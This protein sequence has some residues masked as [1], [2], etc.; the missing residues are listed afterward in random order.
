MNIDF[1]NQIY[2]FRPWQPELGRVYQSG[3]AFDTETT[4]IDDARPYLTPAYVIGAAFDGQ[5]GFFVQR[6]DVAS[7]F[8]AHAGL[9]IAFHNA[10]FDLSVI[11]TVAPKIDI[12]QAVEERRIW[13]TQLLHRLHILGAEG[14]SASR[15]GQS[16]LEHCA[17]LYL[18]IELPKDVTDSAGKPVRLSYGQWLNRAP[19]DIEAVY[20]EYLAKDVVATYFVMVKLWDAIH[21]LAASSREV[22]GFVSDE[23]LNFCMNA[24]GPQTHHIQ[25]RAAIVLKQITANGL[26]LD[27]EHKAELSR[28]LEAR[29]AELR[30]EL[31]K[32]GY[33]PG[34][35]SEKALQAI[36]LRIERDQ[37][38]LHLPRTE[39]GKIQTSQEALQE[40]AGTSEF[41]GL[42]LEYRLTQKLRS[43]FVDK[44]T[45]RRIHPSFDVLATT[46]RTTSFGEINAQN[47]PKDD[48][49]RSC[50][51]P[52][53]GHV[54]FD[55]DY[56]TVEMATLAE[57]CIRQFG[58]E[59][60]MAAAIN[61][62]K[63][64]HTMVAARVL[65][66]DEAA[67]T[68]PDRS[69]AKP[70]NFGKPG[71]MGDATLQRYAKASYE[72]EL[73]AEEVLAFSA[74]WHDTF[75]EMARFLVDTHN[76]PLELAK[77]LDL[78]EMSRREHA[79]ENGAV[80]SYWCPDRHLQPNPILGAMCIKVLGSPKPVTRKGE[81]YSDSDVDYF[82]AKL[83]AKQSCLTAALQ[84]DICLRQ[85][86]PQL[87][88]AVMS[89]VGRAGVFTLTGRLRGA[90]TY[91]ARHNTI[92]QG[93]AADG[94]KLGLWL[95]WRAG[96]RIVNFIHDQVLIEVP[97]NSDLDHHA[98]EIRRLMI[99]GMQAV[100][101]DVR[102][103]VSLA[104]SERWHKDA[105]AVYDNS[106]R[107]RLWQPAA[108]D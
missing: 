31:R 20:L 39:T 35:G 54:F 7:F 41:V 65:G 40:L 46:G 36:L 33:L 8:A 63:D 79:G 48:R 70:I 19:R 14:H 108:T 18:D 101:P 37:P 100:V 16:S 10:P 93:L 34:K 23:W 60:H 25:L 80:N 43:T 56:K 94:A 95:L 97:S 99:D 62:G 53:P 74:A 107:L 57:A 82:W 6:Q 84:K 52:S 1:N 4:L 64:L 47:I 72:V 55:A 78:T 67:V 3:F 15:S 92:F 103:D 81:P 87:Q 58:L 22:W 69:K 11:H 45:R 85:P 2:D 29:L 30:T 26:H 49:I 59:S 61:A 77:F 71:G 51:V 50:F 75:P 38:D 104:A 98:S 44:M 42:L 88:R 68:K 13:D 90:A 91:T 28:G 105:E 21:L 5:R 106:G 76:T 73:T 89:L 24:W 66:K 9:P 86:S 12:Y 83:R 17:K 27:L 96:Y 32:F 102:I